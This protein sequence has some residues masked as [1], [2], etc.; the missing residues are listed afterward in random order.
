MQDT[1]I[2]YPTPHHFQISGGFLKTK[3]QDRELVR[4]V[5]SVPRCRS[6]QLFWS[7]KAEAQ[8]Q[9]CPDFMLNERLVTQIPFAWM[10]GMILRGN[11]RDQPSGHQWKGRELGGSLSKLPP[12]PFSYQEQDQLE[13]DVFFWAIMNAY[14]PGD[15]K[16]GNLLPLEG[17]SCYKGN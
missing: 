4:V 3:G 15:R 6:C 5:D 17:S 12:C 14:G 8:A 11:L 13:D 10:T 7:R 9:E 2:I 1:S 16:Q